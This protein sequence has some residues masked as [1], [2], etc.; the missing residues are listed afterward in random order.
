MDETE[1]TEGIDFSF[2]EEGYDTENNS[3]TSET[4]ETLETPETTEITDTTDQ[5]PEVAS[6]W[7]DDSPYAFL[8][9]D[10]DDDTIHLSKTSSETSS[11]TKPSSE[12][13]EITDTTDEVPE[14]VAADWVLADDLPSMAP[15]EVDTSTLAPS[16][17]SETKPTSETN[18][19]SETTSE[20]LS[21][22]SN[23]EIRVEEYFNTYQQPLVDAMNNLVE[24]PTPENYKAYNEALQNLHSR[25]ASV[26]NRAMAMDSALLDAYGKYTETH[27]TAAKT[28]DALGDRLEQAIQT[29]KEAEVAE[30]KNAK[31]APYNEEL[32]KLAKSQVVEPYSDLKLEINSLK[33][34][35]ER[36]QS[37]IDSTPNEAYKQRLEKEN[38]E[39]RTKLAEFEKTLETYTTYYNAYKDKEEAPKAKAET[40]K[41]SPAEERMQARKEA[42]YNFYKATGMDGTRENAE[43]VLSSPDSTP[44]MLDAATRLISVIDGNEA[45][46]KEESV[47]NRKK[48]AEDIEKYKEAKKEAAELLNKGDA[49]AATNVL[50]EAAADSPVFPLTDEKI[51]VTKEDGTTEELSIVDDV[52]HPT[53]E[54]SS[55][56][57]EDLANLENPTS[58]DILDLIKKYDPTVAA[59]IKAMTSDWDASNTNSG[60][61]YSQRGEQFAQTM[62]EIWNSNDNFFTKVWNSVKEVFKAGKDFKEI[63]KDTQMYQLIKNAQKLTTRA[64]VTAIA[65]VTGGPA[66]AIAA[67]VASL[68]KAQLANLVKNATGDSALAEIYEAF[69]DESLNE[70][71]GD[72]DSGIT[73]YDD[74][75]VSKWDRNDVSNDNTGYN[76]GLIEKQV[77]RK[78]IPSDMAVKIIYRKEPWIRKFHV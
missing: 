62:Q 41:T 14:L 61:Q 56:L 7:S 21:K 64:I 32:Y 17:S 48:M 29:A 63:T 2:L 75:L 19:S 11:E 55:E 67:Y 71:N 38:A 76:K 34:D 57:M 46:K 5:V 18:T 74:T 72:S 53:M 15:T 44:E 50:I 27:M 35:I 51:E 3:E 65:A 23:E 69:G 60:L 16:K 42:D 13:T 6:E 33:K 4:S 24:N 58:E 77:T 59:F 73:N 47:E 70:S 12:T 39:N 66:V 49:V 68:G 52:I 36:T 43:E 10:D 20:T 9:S 37:R 40:P 1:N 30:A 31:V 45:S 22:K 26:F 78:E 54:E 8:T 25:G 28:A